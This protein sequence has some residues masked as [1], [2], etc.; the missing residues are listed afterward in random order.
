MKLDRTRS[1]GQTYGDDAGKMPLFQDNVYFTTQGDVADCWYNREHSPHLFASGAADE[2]AQPV[3][4][5]KTDKVEKDD[6]PPDPK[7]AS[8]AAKTDTEVYSAALKLRAMLD[9][10]KDADAFVPDPSDRNANTDFILRH[11]S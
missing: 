5:D 3:K 7:A 4:S 8:L 11:W 6:K 10:S 1:F 2:V 9:E